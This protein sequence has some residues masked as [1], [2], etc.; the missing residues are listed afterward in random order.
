MSYNVFG[1]LKQVADWVLIQGRVSCHVGTYNSSYNKDRCHHS[2]FDLTL[3]L[4]GNQKKVAIATW[5]I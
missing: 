3:R 5:C 1:H 2:N 4:R